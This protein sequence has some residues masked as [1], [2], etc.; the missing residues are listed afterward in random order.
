MVICLIN[1]ERFLFTKNRSCNKIG[2][3]VLLYENK[4]KQQNCP[5]FVG[6][7]SKF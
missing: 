2:V 6:C 4:K 1:I 5:S 3:I 7:K